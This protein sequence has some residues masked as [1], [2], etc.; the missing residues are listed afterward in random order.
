[1]SASSEAY[2]IFRTITD[3]SV[4]ALGLSGE[5][6]VVESDSNAFS[7]FYTADLDSLPFCAV[8]FPALSLTTAT[9]PLHRSLHPFSPSSTATSKASA[10]AARA[11]SSPPSL[12]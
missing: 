6:E 8:S 9:K 7:Q 5:L 2:S 3:E 1:M 4:L 11:P 12:S 10:K